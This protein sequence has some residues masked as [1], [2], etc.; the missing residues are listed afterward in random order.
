MCMAWHHRACHEEHGR[1]AACGVGPPERLVVAPWWCE[2]PWA[3]WGCAAGPARP[4]EPIATGAPALVPRE[5]RHPPQGRLAAAAY[6]ALL[7]VLSLVAAVLA[8]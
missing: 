7:A 6:L 2:H 3:P 5:E 1:C 8:V 4:V